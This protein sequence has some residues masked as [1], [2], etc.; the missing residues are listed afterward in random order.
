MFF[1]CDRSSSRHYGAANTFG[2]NHPM[3]LWPVRRRGPTPAFLRYS[4]PKVCAQARHTFLP[5]AGATGRCLFVGFV[6]LWVCGVAGLDGGAGGTGLGTMPG[7]GTVPGWGAMNG[8]RTMCG[9]SRGIGLPRDA[10]S[11]A[12]VAAPLLV[13][14]GAPVGD[15]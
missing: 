1:C 6:P 3:A 9:T 15:S 12:L 10:E 11:V 2:A 4:V 8:G 5:S 13:C 14:R 7:F